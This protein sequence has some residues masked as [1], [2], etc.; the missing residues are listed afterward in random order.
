LILLPHLA[1]AQCN[2]DNC[3]RAVANNRAGS[4]FLAAASV[5]CSSF[6]EQT[7]FV[8][9]ATVSGLVLPS[10]GVEEKSLPLYAEDACAADAGRYSSAC[11]CFGVGEGGTVT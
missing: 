2:R 9:S 10:G 1:S 8:P 4:A 6:L 5:D 11:G 7:V 3:L